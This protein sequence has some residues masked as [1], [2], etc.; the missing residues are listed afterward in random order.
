MDHASLSR[1]G[2]SRKPAETDTRRPIFRG[3]RIGLGGCTSE[4][5]ELRAGD[6]FV[7]LD[8]AHTG[9]DSIAE[10]IG[11]A[12]PA[13]FAIAR[14]RKRTFQFAWFPMPAKPTA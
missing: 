2:T 11:V 14:C 3:R 1:P 10:A 9:S 4:L 5:H 7:A 8:S 12:R 13:S 6:L